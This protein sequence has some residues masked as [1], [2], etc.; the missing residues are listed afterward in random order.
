MDQAK[1]CIDNGAY[2][3]HSVLPYFKGPHAVIPGYREQPQVT[4]EEFASYIALAPDRQFIS[5]DRSTPTPST[6]CAR[7]SPG[8]ARPG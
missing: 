2:L 3:E 7:S 8:C 5:T 1:A 4:M 6:G